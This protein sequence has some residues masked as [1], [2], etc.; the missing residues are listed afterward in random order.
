MTSSPIQNPDFRC[1]LIAIVGRP[2]VGKSTLLNRLIGEK[3]SITSHKAQ[4]T[5]HHILGIHHT[6]EAQYVFVDTPGFQQKHRQ[7]LNKTLN[8]TMQHTLQ[9][10]D[11]AMWVIESTQ[12]KPEDLLVLEQIPLDMPCIVV[13]NKIDLLSDKLN[14][15]PLMAKLAQLRQ[16]AEII[17][18]TYKQE[19][20]IEIVLHALKP[21]LPVQ[22][23]LYDAELY[24]TQTQRF[25]AAE[26][27]R[28][29]IFRFTGDEL[30]YQTTVVIERFEEAKTTRDV[31]R[32]YACILVEKIAHKAMIIGKKGERL[33]EM[34]TLARQDMERA[35]GERVYLNVWVKVKSGWADH[36]ASIKAY[37]YGD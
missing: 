12:L 14:L 3:V 21:H 28:E 9:G 31:T 23:P 22:A 33:K 35:W 16:F 30:P 34:A 6:S 29:K 15:L 36:E 37:G 2:N 27:I 32:V 8:K 10:V 24:T 5:R 26:L 25:V 7:A 19:R 4:T 1:G 20:H 13:C 11:M 17:P 18:Y